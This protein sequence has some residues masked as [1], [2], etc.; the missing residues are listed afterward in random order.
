M[1]FGQKVTKHTFEKINFFDI[2]TFR[3][4]SVYEPHIM[5]LGRICTQ[6]KFQKVTKKCFSCKI[7]K[8]LLTT[9]WLER[10]EIMHSLPDKRPYVH[11]NERQEWPYLYLA[12]LQTCSELQ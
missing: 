2:L 12:V 10:V 6:H 11:M 1:S 8:M 5:S 7:C 9:F 4:M 3:Q